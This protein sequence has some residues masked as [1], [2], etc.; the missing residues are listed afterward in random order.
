MTTIMKPEAI[1]QAIAEACGW[2]KH[3]S[4]PACNFYT[5]PYVWTPPEGGGYHNDSELPQYTTDLNAMHEAEKVL[6]P[7]KHSD[8]I[9]HLYYK[10]MGLGGNIGDWQKLA[11][12]TAAQRAEAFLKTLNLWT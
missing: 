8:Y 11:T 12:A 2:E 9:C 3:S 5:S 10:T 7:P 1:N 6:S 4:P